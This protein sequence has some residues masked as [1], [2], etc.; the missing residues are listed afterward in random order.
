MRQQN[1]VKAAIYKR[2]QKIVGVSAAGLSSRWRGPE[3]YGRKCKKELIV[4][5]LTG[6]VEQ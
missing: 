6:Y 3:V 5:Q 2:I 1:F 4:T